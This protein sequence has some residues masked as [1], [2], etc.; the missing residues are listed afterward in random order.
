M[1]TG[2]ATGEMNSTSFQLHH[3][4]QIEGRQSTSRPDFYRREV[5]GSQHIPMC[6]QEGLPRSG[7]FASRRWFNAMRLQN[8]GNGRITDGVANL[9]ELALNAI[10]SPCWILPREFHRQVDDHLTNSRSTWL[11]RFTV[12]V[13]PLFGDELSMPTQDRIRCE[14]SADF[15]QQLSAEYLSLHG[16]SSPLIIVEQDSFLTELFLQNLVFSTQVFDDFL[17][18]AVDPAGKVHDHQMPGLQYEIHWCLGD[19]VKP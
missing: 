18:L 1:W 2:C 6:F 7:A 9:S 12:G 13:I 17:L 14:Q 5:D 11:V 8:V 10:E 4:Q 15:I 16:Q 19:R 3:E